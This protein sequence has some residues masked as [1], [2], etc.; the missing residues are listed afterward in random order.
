MYFLR[1]MPNAYLSFFDLQEEPFST[2]ANP[3]YVYL[4]PMHAAALK[5]TSFV[6]D[7]KN[8][9]AV[10]FGDTGTGKSSLARMLHLEFLDKGY[11]S[12]LLT[13]PKSPTPNLLLRTIIQEFRVQTT[14]AYNDNIKAFK[15]YMYKEAVEN[16]KTLVLIID[17]AHTLTRPFF[18]ML[19]Q[20]M[21]YETNELKLLQIVLFAQEELRP[22]LKHP[23]V[24]NFK[25]RIVMA[26]TLE[27]LAVDDLADL[28]DFRWRAASGN[29]KH[30]FTEEA[31]EL[32]YEACKSRLSSRQD[33][34]LK[35]D[36]TCS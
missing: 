26:S 7:S 10:V 22:K 18:E 21:N 13:N 27:K 14:R 23:Q 30:P 1:I 17:E 11:T 15:E 3:R 12:I 4:T 36:I 31:I 8:G 9:L 16:E 20:L 32:I 19:R 35:Y 2:S 33:C 6:V 5:K 24:R 25:S 34:G 28:I 29:K